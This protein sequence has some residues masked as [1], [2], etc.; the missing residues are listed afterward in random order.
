[1]FC[2][3]CDQP[4]LRGQAYETVDIDQPTSAGATVRLHKKLCPRPPRQTAPVEPRRRIR[5]C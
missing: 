2:A 3:R 5:G 1:M 4:I